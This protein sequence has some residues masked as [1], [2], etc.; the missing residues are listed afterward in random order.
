[1]IPTP[2]DVA[3]MVSQSVEISL[4]A[5]ATAFLLVGLIGV[6]LARRA[7]ASVRHLILAATFVAIAATPLLMNGI[8]ETRI[9]IPIAAATAPAERPVAAPP[10]STD[11][12]RAANQGRVRHP[13]KCDVSLFLNRWVA[14]G[15]PHQPRRPHIPR[16]GHPLP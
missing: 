11:R 3:L 1:M 9:A 4:L 12:S 15:V 6:A 14:P 2:A 13:S 5:K 8:P 7:R 10:E 16:W